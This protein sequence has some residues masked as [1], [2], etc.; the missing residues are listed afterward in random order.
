MVVIAYF[1][2]MQ[3]HQLGLY[4]NGPSTWVTSSIYYCLLTLCV[5]GGVELEAWISRRSQSW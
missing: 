2:L 4:A 1:S 3:L 5:V